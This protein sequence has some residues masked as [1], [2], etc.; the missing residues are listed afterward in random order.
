[1]VVD[2]LFYIA[3]SGWINLHTNTI[4]KVFVLPEKYKFGSCLLLGEC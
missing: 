1:M 2:G 3:A 4:C